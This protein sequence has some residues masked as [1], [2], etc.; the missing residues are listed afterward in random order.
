MSNISSGHLWNSIQRCTRCCLTLA[1]GGV[2]LG[3]LWGCAG[4][5][6]QETYTVEGEVRA[7]KKALARGT[8]MFRSSEGSLVTTEIGENG[9]YQVK[10]AAGRHRVAVQIPTEREA[11]K[12]A[13]E[14]FGVIFAKSPIPSKYLYF[15]SSGLN[16]EVSPAADNT[17]DFE[18]P[19]RK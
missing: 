16:V 4:S 17:H 19:L 13:K 8:L 2:F 7:G 11:G 9:S 15:E 12:S 10:L 6:S 14:Q 3:T 1:L 18:L 5:P